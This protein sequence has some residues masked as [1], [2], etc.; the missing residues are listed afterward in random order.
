LTSAFGRNPNEDGDKEVKDISADA[1]TK[2][3][4]QKPIRE[5]KLRKVTKKEE[6]GKGK[7]GDVPREDTRSKAYSL[8]RGKQ[9]AGK[10]KRKKQ[11][12]V[13][14]GES[15]QMEILSSIFSGKES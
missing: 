2:E 11:K 9:K 1:S 12:L 7:D 6:G 10:E 3:S 13:K 4:E 8:K 14:D 5:G 15:K